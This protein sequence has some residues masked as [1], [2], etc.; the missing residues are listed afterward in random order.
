MN[1]I[2]KNE[3]KIRYI[4]YIRRWKIQEKHFQHYMEHWHAC[5]C[6]WYAV[7]FTPKRY[8]FK[9]RKKP[10]EK[11]CLFINVMNNVKVCFTYRLFSDLMKIAFYVPFFCFFFFKVLYYLFSYN[12]D[13]VKYFD[14]LDE[15]RIWN[16]W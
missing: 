13:N 16:L 14:S 8:K 2:L 1:T 11:R 10:L 7:L 6:K 15:I 4:I 3:C 12:L 5:T 9:K